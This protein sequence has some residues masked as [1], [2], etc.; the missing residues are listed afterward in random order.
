MHVILVYKLNYIL[1]FE[2]TRLLRIDINSAN[3]K[4]LI[5]RINWTTSAFYFPLK[6]ILI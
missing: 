2:S 1:I 5:G 3:P 4:V 6:M